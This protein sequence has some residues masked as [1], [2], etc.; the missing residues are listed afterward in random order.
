MDV[1]FAPSLWPESFGLVTREAAACGCWVV[2]SDLGGIG[3]DIVESKTGYLIHPTLHS[4]LKV[5]VKLDKSSETHKKLPF[6]N[7]KYC[8]N[9]QVEKL[10]ELYCYER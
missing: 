3:E 4:V 1:L 6:E 9:V 10:L 7:I 8:K 2:A 5:I